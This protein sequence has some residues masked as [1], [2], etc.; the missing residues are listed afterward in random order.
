MTPELPGNVKYIM[1]G[2]CIGL[3]VL[4]NY[5]YLFSNVLF[6]MF[7]V[8]S[9]CSI[10]VYNIIDDKIWEQYFIPI[11]TLVIFCACIIYLTRLIINPNLKY[12][13]IRGLIF[14]IIVTS[15]IISVINTSINIKSFNTFTSE[16]RGYI[17][18]LIYYIFLYIPCLVVDILK[19]LHRD[20]KQT[21]T[22]T[23]I[24][25]VV[26]VT[27]ILWNYV[28][29]LSNIMSEKYLIDNPQKLNQE[30][31]N[32]SINNPIEPFVSLS[33]ADLNKVSVDQA[34][35]TINQ[36]D[37]IK[38]TDITQ[39]SR[40]VV[41]QVKGL[42]IENQI[43][44]NKVKSNH[45]NYSY[46]ISF[47]LYLDGQIPSNGSRAL[48]M[49]FGKRPSMYYDYIN[50]VLVVEITSNQPRIFTT[51][52]YQKWNHIV[53][54]Y[55]NGTFDLFINNE[56]VSTE[57]DAVNLI[58]EDDHIIVGSHLNSDIGS[59]SKFIYFDHALSIS[60]IDQLN[61]IK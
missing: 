30:I 1:I 33:E 27:Y 6:H 46:A 3:L 39:K 28:F 42:N 5:S 19:P 35:D 13:L 57:K 20:Y 26:L 23:I 41:R 38:M 60:K 32:I 43:N 50:K 14:Y 2:V 52:L 56:L 4:L 18:Q 53:F 47:W 12:T 36:L 54:N 25:F 44:E 17:I 59:I 10:F 55:V 11:I 58:G 21:N 49:S 24:L 51:P 16:Q 45:S 8:F 48:I 61:K 31:I 7:F 40:T 29:P 15:L 37:K 9:L 34:V 22:T